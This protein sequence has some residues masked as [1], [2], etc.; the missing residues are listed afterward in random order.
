MAAAAAAVLGER[1]GGGVVVGVSPDP[2]RDGTRLEYLAGGHPLPDEGSQRAGTRAL[3][4]AGST[5]SDL[6]CDSVASR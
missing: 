2:T 5:G 6:A 1:L 4:V 3:A